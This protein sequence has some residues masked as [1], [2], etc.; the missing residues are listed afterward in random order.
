MLRQITPDI[1][2]IGTDDIHSHLFE[3]QYPIP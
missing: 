3:S 1:I 2:Y